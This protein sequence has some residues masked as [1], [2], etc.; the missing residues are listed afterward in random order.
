MATFM[1]YAPSASI[2]IDNYIFTSL[3]LNPIPAFQIENSVARYVR[4]FARSK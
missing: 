1:A 4:L 3:R 2:V